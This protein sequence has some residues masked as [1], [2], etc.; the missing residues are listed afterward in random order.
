MERP[1]RTRRSRRALLGLLALLALGPVAA[2]AEGGRERVPLRW[3]LVQVGPHERS[4]EISYTYGGCQQA[5]RTALAETATSVSITATV[6]D[7][8]VS[9]PCPAFAVIAFHTVVLAH[10]LE[11]RALAGAWQPSGAMPFGPKGVRRLIGLSPADARKLLSEGGAGTIHLVARYEHRHVPRAR[12][13][14]QNPRAGDAL[15]GSHAIH[16]VVASPGG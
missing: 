6:E 16:I 2:R 9:G 14:A 10:P 15:P 4:L 11:G 12:V 13:I 5:P 7:Q 8:Q 1:A 3:S